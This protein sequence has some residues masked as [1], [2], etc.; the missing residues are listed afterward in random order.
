MHVGERMHERNVVAAFR[1]W[2]ELGAKTKFRRVR[3]DLWRGFGANLVIVAYD[4]I[5]LAYCI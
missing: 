2:R 5:K 1:L 4:R 3:A